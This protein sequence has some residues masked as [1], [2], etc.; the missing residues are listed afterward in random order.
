MAENN[1][2]MRGKR[3]ATDVISIPADMPEVD[4]LGD[5]LFCLPFIEHQVAGD[6]TLDLNQHC[7]LLLVHSMLHLAGHDHE[8]DADWHRMLAEEERL[9]QQLPRR[10]YFID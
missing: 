3:G 6:S 4:D 9:Q 7:E 1:W 2:Q 10:S 8:D 5:I